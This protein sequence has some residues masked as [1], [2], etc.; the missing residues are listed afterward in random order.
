MTSDKQ[1]FP[2]EN[3]AVSVAWGNTTSESEP[4]VT[5]VELSANE[6][7]AYSVVKSA[8]LMDARSDIV[9]WLTS[10]LAEAA[11]LELDNQGFNGTGTPFFGILTST[12][13]GYSVT[14]AGTAF[15][16]VSFTNL[17]DMIAKLDGLKKQGARFWMHGQAIHYI[18]I[19]RDDN[20]RPIFYETVGMPTSGTILGFPYSEVIKMPSTTAANTAFL[21]FGNLRY[22]AVGR[23]LEV[24]TLSVNPYL[25]WT[26]NRMAYKLYQR[27]GMYPALK[28][29]FV[30]ML[31]HSA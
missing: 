2:M 25:L 6:L 15:E 27:W 19:L 21:A 7:S 26:T 30:R 11:G 13:A 28:N 20:N 23:R 1:S 29:G 22:Y 17:S 18:R 8:T 31:T 24:S 5:E 10:A 12:G 9:S 4:G 16:D 3:A 14:L